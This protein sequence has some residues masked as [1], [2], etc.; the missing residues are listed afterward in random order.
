MRARARVAPG[1]SGLQAQR[2]AAI[3]IAVRRALPACAVAGGSAASTTRTVSDQHSA[4]DRARL[5]LSSVQLLAN[6]TMLI[7]AGG[8]G[9]PDWSRCW[10]TARKQAGRRSSSSLTGMATTKPSPMR[11]TG[12]D[13]GMERGA[14]PAT[15]ESSNIETG[16]Q[17]SRVRTRGNELHPLGASAEEPI[18]RYEV[19]QRNVLFGKLLTGQTQGWKRRA[20]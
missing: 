10:A 20:V 4:R 8:I 2:I 19:P 12:P 16:R 13:N 15:N 11:E 14:T 18:N 9:C 1:G 17:T 7:R 3:S 5:A 6:T